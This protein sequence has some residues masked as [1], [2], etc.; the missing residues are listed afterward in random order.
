VR[1]NNAPYIF[2]Q[3]EQMHGVG[4]GRNEIEMPIKLLSVFFLC[5]DGKR[6]NASNVGSL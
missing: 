3:N 5:M 1:Q 2:Q 4:R 6:T